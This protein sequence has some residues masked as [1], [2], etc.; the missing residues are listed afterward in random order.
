[1][2]YNNVM[3]TL[4]TLQELT[5]QMNLEPAEDTV[6]SRSLGRTKPESYAVSHALLPNGSQIRLLKTLL[7]SACER[8]CYYCPFR[9]GRDFRRASLSPDEMASA[10]MGFHKAGIV[11][12]IFLSSGIA[13]G[14]LRTQ[15]QL[16]ATAEILRSKYGF[17]GYIHLKLMPGIEQ[18]Q[19]ERSMQLADRVSLNLE[20]PNSERLGKLAPRKSFLDELMQTMRWVEDIRR[21]HSPLRGWNGHWPSLTTQFVVGAVGESDLELLSTTKYLHDQFRLSRAYF[22]AFNPIIDT[23]FENLPAETPIRE[24]RLYQASYLLRDYG[25]TLAD[26]PFDGDGRLPKAVD[27]K[28]AWAQTHLIDSPVEINKADRRQLLQ[29]PG[30]GP[31]GADAIMGAR[32]RGA[33]YNLEDLSK[34]GI[35]PF[36]LIPYILL[37][38]KR[39]QKQLTLW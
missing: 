19:I 34:I 23:P 17:R 18:A 2:F 10:F 27:P 30:I 39:P 15:D 9:A 6:Y 20:A 33:I 29:V 11:E 25:F 36:R 35:H 37:N 4:A 12:G 7:T 13:G 26:L 16:I 24:H 38:G 32:R 28:V 31:K 21:N 3:N 1:M 5:C 8:N 14:S 22:S